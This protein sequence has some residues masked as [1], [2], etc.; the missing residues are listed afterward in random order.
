MPPHKLARELY[1]EEVQNVKSNTM[2]TRKLNELL[3]ERQELNSEIVSLNGILQR[4]FMA[5]VNSH[6]NQLLSEKHVYLKHINR[7]IEEM[8]DLLIEAA[9]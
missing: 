2:N 8:E 6:E 4:M 9:Q 7:Q 1:G 3:I 5:M